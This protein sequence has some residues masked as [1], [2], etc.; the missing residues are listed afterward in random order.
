ML[1]VPIV[2]IVVVFTKLDLFLARLS[3]RGEAKVKSNTNSLEV[4]ETIFKEKYGRVFDK[5][6]K[7]IEG[8]IPYALVTTSAFAPAT[9]MFVL[10]SRS[11][12]S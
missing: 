2:P 8:H 7:N 5:S 11:I 10:M 6:T 3:R 4:A 12:A 9:T 1:I